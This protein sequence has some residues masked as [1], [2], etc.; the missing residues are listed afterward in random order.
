MFI[1][2][3]TIT[4][5]PRILSAA[6]PEGDCTGSKN[7]PS[8]S[9]DLCALLWSELFFFFFVRSCK[10]FIG[11]STWAYLV[12]LDIQHGFEATK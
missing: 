6:V 8:V 10:L 5:I 12:M 1:I 4:E 11:I 2:D 9:I 7:F 3:R